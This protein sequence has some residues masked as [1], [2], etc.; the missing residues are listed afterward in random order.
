MK[1][2]PQNAK[3]PHWMEAAVLSAR[4]SQAAKTLRAILPALLLWVQPADLDAATRVEG[5]VRWSDGSSQTGQLSLTPNRQ[6]KLIDRQASQQYALELEQVAAIEFIEESAGMEQNWRFPVAGQTRKEK[7]GDPYP[8]RELGARVRLRSGKTL[9]GHLYTTVLYLE[10]DREVQKFVLKSKQKGVP[11][12][13]LDDLV[14]PSAI[15]FAHVGKEK[16]QAGSWTVPA[17]GQSGVVALAKPSLDRHEGRRTEDGFSFPEP[18]QPDSAFV[19]ARYEDRL[20]VAWPYPP[21]EAAASRIHAALPDFKDFLDE[22][23]V[24]AAMVDNDTIYALLMLRR[25]G[26]STY[27][28]ERNQPWRLEIFRWKTSDNDDNIILGGRGYFFR[29]ILAS[30]EEPPKVVLKS[31]LDAPAPEPARRSLPLRLSPEMQGASAQ[32]KTARQHEH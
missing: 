5:T 32:P 23:E 31:S 10:A 16:S 2:K 25:R 6:L 26:P 7:S 19:A 29:G 17:S 30:H 21:D 13:S 28:A 24:K 9:K 18:I 1:K 27:G 4:Q 22:S 20:V 14:Y 15:T 3:A 8:V 12:E 11:G